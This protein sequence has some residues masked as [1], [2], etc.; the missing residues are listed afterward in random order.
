M[1]AAR[2]RTTNEDNMSERERAF[3][4]TIRAALL[5]LVAAIERYA[6][7]GKCSKSTPIPL[8]NSQNEDVAGLP[9]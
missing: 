3:W 4:I 1:G 9:K 6:E 2:G 7:I 5:E 8:Q